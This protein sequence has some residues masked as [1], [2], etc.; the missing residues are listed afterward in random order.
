MGVRG[1]GWNFL[2]EDNIIRYLIVTIHSLEN[3]KR[4]LFLIKISFP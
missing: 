4:S 2:F 3:S 1:E